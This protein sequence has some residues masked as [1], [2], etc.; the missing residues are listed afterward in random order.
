MKKLFFA[1]ILLTTY[2]IFAHSGRGKPPRLLVGIVASPDLSYR[3]LSY[4][5]GDPFFDHHIRFRNEREQ[6]KLGVTTGMSMV[7]NFS[8]NF[9]FETGLYFSNKGEREAFKAQGQSE[10]ID[11]FYGFV[12]TPLGS[13]EVRNTYSY[14]YLDIPI[15]AIYTVHWGKLQLIGGIGIQANVFL[16]GYKKTAV[17]RDGALSN[18]RRK[19]DAEYQFEPIT[20]SAMATLGVGYQFRPKWQLRVEPVFRHGFSSFVNQS[21]KSYLW[22]AGVQFG[23]YYTLW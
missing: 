10:E 13:L 1:V 20:F 11:L 21:I 5:G 8:K 7:Y 22:S 23:C 19:L 16:A 17:N 6:P 3:N 18:A 2:P 9:G 12:G 4:S 14:N 15:R